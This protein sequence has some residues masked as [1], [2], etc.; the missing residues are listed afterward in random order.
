[1][2][3]KQGTRIIFNYQDNKTP[4]RDEL[5]VIS[6]YLITRSNDL[7]NAEKTI[8]E[9]YDNRSI[10][11]FIPFLYLDDEDAKQMIKGANVELYHLQNVSTPQHKDRQWKIIFPTVERLSFIFSDGKGHRVDSGKNADFIMQEMISSDD[12]ILDGSYIMPAVT[13]YR[14]GDE[15][16]LTLTFTDEGKSKFNSFVSK[17]KDEYVGLFSNGMLVGVA[18]ASEKIETNQ[19]SITGFKTQSAVKD[20]AN[21]IMIGDLPFELKLENVEILNKPQE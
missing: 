7:F 10:T 19:V 11:I 17:N 20:V 12:K 9:K 1:M 8:I 15:F 3:E 16:M 2:P 14:T 13:Y 5:A 4:T 18:I 6:K 21:R